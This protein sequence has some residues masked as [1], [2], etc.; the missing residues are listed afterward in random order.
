M[1]QKR[2]G[3]PENWENDGQI[4]AT[5]GE[6]NRRDN[7]I[8]KPCGHET[9][10]DISARRRPGAGGIRTDNFLLESR[11]LSLGHAVPACLRA[12]AGASRKSRSLAGFAWTNWLHLSAAVCPLP[13]IILDRRPSATS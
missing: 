12:R 4:G 7:I 6:T 8:R 2:Y 1:E 3:I 11:E 5:A 13:A 10:N 9:F